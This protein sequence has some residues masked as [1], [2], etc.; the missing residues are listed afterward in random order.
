MELARQWPRYAQP[1]LPNHPCYLCAFHVPEHIAQTSQSLSGCFLYLAN[2]FVM[3]W[4][5]EVPHGVMP[6]S[7]NLL[8]HDRSPDVMVLSLW[9]PMTRDCATGWAQAVL[10]EKFNKTAG[11]RAAGIVE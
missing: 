11:L 8:R 4:S 3:A 6:S 2:Q 5:E 1:R 7:Q 9:M 10:Q